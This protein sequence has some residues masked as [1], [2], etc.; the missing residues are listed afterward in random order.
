MGS[1]AD[2]SV[3]DPSDGVASLH[4]D[5]D[6]LAAEVRSWYVQAY[7]DMGY[8]AEERWFGVLRGN[9]G[10]DFASVTLASLRPDQVAAMTAEVA[11]VRGRAR[12]TL[13]VPSDAYSDE[14]HR[15]LVDDGWEADVTQTHLAHVGPLPDV[16]EP[17]GFGLEQVG[18]DGLEAFSRVKIMGFASSEDEPT[19]EQIEHEVSVRRAEAGGEPGSAIATV[20]TEPAG[21]VAWYGGDDAMIFL[22]ATRVPFRGR[23]VASASIRRVLEERYASGCRSVLINGDADGHPVEIY[24][25]LGFT[26]EV[27]REHRYARS[28]FS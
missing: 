19:R 2:P 28:H 16:V 8:T 27:Y 10:F 14:L 24:R 13:Q 1:A 23:G 20:D 9:T 17:D 6:E 12:V 3:A 4:P 5:H 7:P 11:E 26:D 18:D 25:S 15:A 22:V 21:I